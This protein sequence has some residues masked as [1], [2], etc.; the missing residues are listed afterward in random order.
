MVS[1]EPLDEVRQDSAKDL[2]GFV[3][4]AQTIEDRRVGAPVEKRRRVVRAD[5]CDADR[6]ASP[7]ERLG[8]GKVAARMGEAGQVVKQRREVVG[9]VIRLS[10]YDPRARR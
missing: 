4:S 9:I 3:G 2:R 7:R 10:L 1:A 8:R 5:G 6:D